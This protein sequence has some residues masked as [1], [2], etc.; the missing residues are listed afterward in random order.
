[1][2]KFDFLA[3]QLDQYQALTSHADPQ[4]GQRLRDVQLWQTARMQHTHA[5][6][7]AEPRHQLMADYFLHRLYAADDFDQL[8][9]QLR[10]IINNASKVEKVIPAS[11]LHTGDAGVELARL[12]LE[13]DE[14]LASDL[15]AHYP[16]DRP[17]TA[18]MMA[19]AYRR[20][21]QFAQRTHQLEL[22]ELLGQKL[23]QYMRSYVVKTA[24]RL[25]KS[26]AYRY[27]VDP[28]YEFIDAGFKAMAPLDSAARFIQTF[29]G[30]ER[31]IL[32]ALQDNTAHPF[33]YD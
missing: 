29:T 21:N 10:R 33:G 9:H 3:Q 19:A 22:L 7:F 25:A 32:Q 4:L 27:G 5:A 23:D 20:T 26:P 13:L 14:Q 8:A 24:F 12:S 17:L 28:I 1:M 11:A 18:E 6:L 30:A 31:A 16:A 15:L 2:S